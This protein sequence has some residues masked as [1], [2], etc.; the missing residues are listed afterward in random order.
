M[1][2]YLQE[3]IDKALAEGFTKVDTSECK[4]CP[5]TYFGDISEYGDIASIYHPETDIVTYIDDEAFT[6]SFA[7]YLRIRPMLFKK[8]GMEC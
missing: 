1:E 8:Y 7:E 6:V 2:K 5:V 3:R 4:E